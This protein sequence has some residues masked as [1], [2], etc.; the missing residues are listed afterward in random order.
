MELTCQECGYTDEAVVFRYICKIGILPTGVDEMRRCPRCGA[1]VFLVM[2]E[3]LE[4]EEEQIRE[5][6]R[7][8]AA[9]PGNSPEFM[10]REA[11]EIIRKLS[12]INMRWNIPE[13]DDFISQRQRELGL[14]LKS[15]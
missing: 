3:K 1:K 4:E 15:N 5:L 7:Q 9:I 12:G 11:R 6:S 10:L 8:L 2:A 13:L 14:G